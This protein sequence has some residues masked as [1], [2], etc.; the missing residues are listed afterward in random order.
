MNAAA[1]TAGAESHVNGSAVSVATTSTLELGVVTQGCFSFGCT[2]EDNVGSERPFQR[3]A[4]VTL[5]PELLVCFR[6]CEH[7]ETCLFR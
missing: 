3:P 5:L 7:K 2:I 4:P 6:L 1:C